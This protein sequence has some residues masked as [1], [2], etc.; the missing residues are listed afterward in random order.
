M[1]RK[2][3]QNKFVQGG[4]IFSV[5]S[6][7]VSFLNYIFNLL[8]AR[9][10]P[11]DIYGEY[12][13]AIVYFG[14]LT[15]PFG[16][17]NV[18]LIRRIGLTSVDERQ[19]LIRIIEK[20]IANFVKKQ[21]LVLILV[22]FGVTYLL[23]TQSNLQPT[24]VV[25][26]LLMTLI[27]LATILYSASLQAFKDFVASGALG[28]IST[29][30]K[31][32]VGL[33]VL[34]LIP[35][36]PT[37]YA[38]IIVSMILA[39]FVARKFATNNHGLLKP[40]EYRL[41]HSLSLFRK[42]SVLIP[43]IATL[44]LVGILSLDVMFVKRFMEPDQVGLYAALSVLGKIIFYLTAPLV[45][46]AYTFFTG[47]D[48]KQD[49]PKV[50][51]ISSILVVLSGGMIFVSYYFFPELMVKLVFGQKFISIAP[52]AYLSA[53]FGIGYSMAYLLIQYL[54]SKNHP[55]SLWSVV[56][57]VAQAVALVIFHESFA[58]MIIIGIGATSLLTLLSLAS[59]IQQQ[60]Q[61]RCHFLTR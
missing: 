55:A 34:W 16:A 47:S 18:L 39:F 61:K 25:W 52:L 3:L 8:V 4:V 7:G 53:I 12:M 51:L 37:L 22:L 23:L 45:A 57:M 1:L 32:I 28:I 20:W 21:Y 31:I 26:I 43:T 38:S 60:P 42:K 13:S 2:L 50:L 49:G 36:L 5:A 58:Q 44:G 30:M 29:L 59:I 10:F 9:F 41:A 6:F 11:L 40:L 48:T 46:V 24:S 17:V 14:L 15:V 54:I 27:S 33:L 56:V 35:S 19:A